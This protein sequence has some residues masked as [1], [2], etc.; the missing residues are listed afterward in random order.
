MNLH[1]TKYKGDTATTF[2][3]YKLTSMGFFVSTPISENA[4]YDLIVDTGEKLYKV[5][6]KYRKGSNG[7]SEIP[8]KTTWSDSNGSHSK[9][10]SETDFDFFAIVN[11]NYDKFALCPIS[12]K[13]SSI[14]WTPS[15]S[16]TPFYWFDDF[17]EFSENI[18]TKKTYKDFGITLKHNKKQKTKIS[19]PSDETLAILLQESSMVNIGKSLGVSDNAVRKHCKRSGLL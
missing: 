9:Y 18:P 1:H 10:I 7:S 11:E 4:P 16:A 3:I 2:I 17:Q 6:V 15:N 5:Q 19:W 12:L 14:R 8:E 13:G